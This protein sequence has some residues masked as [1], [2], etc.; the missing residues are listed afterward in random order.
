MNQP[1]IWL[2]EEALRVTHPVFRAAPEGT[3]AIYVWDEEY[4]R[5][6][7]YSLKRLVF[8]YETLCELHV[9]ILRGDNVS[10]IK[11]IAPS[12]LYIPATTK[13]HIEATISKIKSVANVEMIHDE[14]FVTI[15]K[16]ADIRRFFPYWNMAQKTAFQKN[17]DID[18]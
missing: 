15:T 4:L 9:E 3:R 17:G 12:I 16:S 8:M 11:Q 6:L 10:I 2:H 18:A 1:L 7:D 13:P 5:Q 14:N